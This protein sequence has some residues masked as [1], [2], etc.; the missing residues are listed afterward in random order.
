MRNN[1]LDRLYRF[2]PRYGPEWGSGGIFGLKYYRNTLYFNLAFEAQ[3]HFVS[4]DGDKTYNYGLVG[5]QPVSGGDSY[6]A[7]D[8]VDD[9]LYFGGWVHA[10]AV[11]ES[12][13]RAI[14]FVNKYSHVHE[15]DLREGKV[16]LLWKEGL[17]HPTD[18][19]GEVSEIVYDPVSDALL[20]ARADG[21]ANR[22]IYSLDRKGGAISQL[23]GDHAV[24]G[25]LFLDYACFD[26]SYIGDITGVQSMHLSTRKWN[27]QQFGDVSK[28]SV[29]GGGVLKPSVGCMTSSYARLFVFVKGGA[30]VGNPIEP[31]REPMKFVRLFDFVHSGYSPSRT[32][33]LPLGGGILTSFN[34]FTH[35]FMNP[36]NS[37]ESKAAQVVN[38][39]V[40]PSLLVYVTPPMARIVG[41]LG[42]RV[43]SLESY[44]DKILVGTSTAA[45]LARFDATPIDVGYRDIL[46]LD[47]KILFGAA[48]PVSFSI[49]GHRIGNLT[50][51]GFPL[52]GYK[53]AL[54]TFRASRANRLHVFEY[55]FGLPIQGAEEDIREL[56]QGKNFLDL[57]DYHGIISFRLDEEDQD[58]RINVHLE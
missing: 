23:S 32:V 25:T 7:V 57:K 44:G 42:A 53:D 31:E 16:R 56:K 24:K 3:A 26:M 49:P 51:G 10:P 15:Y 54:M 13:G 58:A 36:A 9:S 18:W 1:L 48:P 30:L 6:N 17:C 27:K 33:A 45:N 12:G 4:G 29:D 19:T 21:H 40:G 50:W 46:P 55:D 35:G 47:N 41:V 28:M 8:V 37:D 11:L 20:L 39:I 38:T 34:A 52:L 22:G 14:S 43:T 5:P 2:P